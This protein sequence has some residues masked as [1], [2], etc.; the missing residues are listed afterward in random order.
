[1]NKRNVERVIHAIEKADFRNLGFNMDAFVSL[2]YEDRRE[3]HACGTT[4]CIGGFAKMLFC[5]DAKMVT[6][7]AQPKQLVRAINSGDVYFSVGEEAEEFLELTPAQAEELFFANN[8]RVATGNQL[9]EITAKHAVATLRNLLK[10]GRVSWAKT[11][12][13]IAA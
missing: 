7:G 10:T 1:M 3:K 8:Y 12:K 4:A 9:Q 13:E 6:L 5:L 2:T 11:A